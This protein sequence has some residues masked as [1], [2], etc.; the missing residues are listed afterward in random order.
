MT[1]SVQKQSSEEEKDNKRRE[2]DL[3]LFE[4]KT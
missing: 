3:H 2:L 4:E 1:W